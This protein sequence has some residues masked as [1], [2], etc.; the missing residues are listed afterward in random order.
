MAEL[1]WDERTLDHKSD[2]DNQLQPL[3][4]ATLEDSQG[5]K[6]VT[7]SSIRKASSYPVLTFF[8]RAFLVPAS[9]LNHILIQ[10]SELQKF[11]HTTACF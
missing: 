2:P 3:A 5:M 4:I 11:C 9:Y 8:Q 6:E 10:E 1:G 7:A